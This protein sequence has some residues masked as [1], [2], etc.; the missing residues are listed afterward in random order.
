MIVMSRFDGVSM[1]KWNIVDVEL[2]EK[3]PLTMGVKLCLREIRVSRGYY[4]NFAATNVPHLVMM[5]SV[6]GFS[7]GYRGSGPYDLALN[8]IEWYLRFTAFEGET[9][10]GIDGKCFRLAEKLAPEFIVH[11]IEPIR[12]DRMVN[13]LS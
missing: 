3:L 6:T 11:F 2:E 4:N 1:S 9:V 10:K 13:G 12:N 7:W 5:H 8:I